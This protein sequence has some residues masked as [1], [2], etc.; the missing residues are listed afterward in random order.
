MKA[1]LF[2]TF[3]TLCLVLFAHQKLNIQM[4][5]NR[6]TSYDTYFPVDKNWLNQSL[7]HDAGKNSDAN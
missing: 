7:L 4:V 3:I 1:K 2:K 5:E 6:Q